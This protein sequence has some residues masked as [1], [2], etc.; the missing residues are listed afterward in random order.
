MSLSVNS[1]YRP[2]FYYQ[3]KPAPLKALFFSALLF[4]APP[5]TSGFSTTLCPLNNQSVL[6]PPAMRHIPHSI[7]PSLFDK[8]FLGPVNAARNG[9]AAHLNW[10]LENRYTIP[11]DIMLHAVTSGNLE[12][13]RALKEY[14]INTVFGNTTPLIVAIQQAILNPRHIEMVKLLF[15]LGADA[16]HRHNLAPLD[17]INIALSL[18]LSH[19]QR[20]RAIVLKKILLSYGAKT[21]IETDNACKRL[22]NREIYLFCKALKP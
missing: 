17:A 22:D 3:Q 19:D 18:N 2:P 16:N 21:M 14:S 10:Y 12:C 20:K 8:L 6:L 7:E 11:P 9:N 1:S 13:V 5:I 15:M 4:S